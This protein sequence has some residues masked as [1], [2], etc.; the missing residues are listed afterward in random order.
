MSLIV[1]P[2]HLAVNDAVTESLV[3]LLRQSFSLQTSLAGCIG[4]WAA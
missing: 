2:Q 4:R 3:V 1:A